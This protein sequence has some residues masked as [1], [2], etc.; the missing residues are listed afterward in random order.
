M[1]EEFEEPK[2]QPF[3]MER[4]LDL[5]RR[6]HLSFLLM[7]FLGWLAVWGVSWLLPLRYKSGTLILVEAPSL[8]K[9]YVVPNVNDSLQDRLQSLTQQ[10][11]SRTHLLLIIDRLHLYSDSHHAQTPDEKVETMRKDIDIELVRDPQNRITAFRVSYSAPNPH[12]AQQVTSEL[13]NLFIEENLKV[14]A[15]QSENTTEF[16]SSQLENARG[17][18]AEQEAKVRAYQAF[19]IG[20]LPSQQGSN[21]QILSGL[22]AQLQSEQDALNSARQQSVYH[23]TLIQQ[24]RALRGTPRTSSGAP[25]GL[26]AIDQQLENLRE[27]LADLSSRYTDSHP[28]V[29][30]VRA[31]IAKTEKMKEQLIASLNTEAGRKEQSSDIPVP[32]TADPTQNA[33]VL[34][35]QSQLRADQTEISNRE[36]AIANL[37]S[38]TN[39]YQARLSREPAVEQQLAELKRGYDQSQA[40]Y[41]DLL[42][43]KN[44]SQ[45]AT[46]M[47]QM[48]QGERFTM[49]DPPSLPLRP[50]SPNRLKMCGIAAAAGL[51]LGLL[52]VVL[53]EFVDDRLHSDREI[54]KLLPVA[55]I[56]EIPE[57]LSRRDERR[58]KRKAALGWAFATVVVLVMLA[59]SA[60]SY[61][62]T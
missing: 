44:D 4:Y 30:G 36:Q 60:F 49:L 29:Q 14:R 54:K 47:E 38:R 33:L 41:N 53:L 1:S 62:H 52:A 32:E 19:H 20:E 48:Q 11:L 3:D 5:L 7:L 61:L 42:K 56:C 12:I 34:Q 31:E 13:T 28:E 2:P 24:Y 21:L 9:D 46:S 58:Q 27:K 25:T 45:M 15:Q 39:E 40:D 16:L 10:I 57:I 6:R 50:D 43:K 55:V 51:G 37:R 35:L 22:Q 17:I 18:L 23:Q 8:P 26:P 59:G